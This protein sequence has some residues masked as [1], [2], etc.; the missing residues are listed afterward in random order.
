MRPDVHLPLSVRK[1]LL[2]D[3]SRKCSSSCVATTVM[4]SGGKKGEIVEEKRATAERKETEGLPS[5]KVDYT[6]T[7]MTATIV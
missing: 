2:S 1:S 3:R 4:T 6:T 5:G 7:T